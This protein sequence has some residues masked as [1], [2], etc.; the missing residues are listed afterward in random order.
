MIL[1]KEVLKITFIT[2]LHHVE[3]VI[4]DSD[5]RQLLIAQ[6]KAILTFFNKLLANFK[7]IEL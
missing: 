4:S 1:L 6:I 2:T 3:R 5:G 7:K